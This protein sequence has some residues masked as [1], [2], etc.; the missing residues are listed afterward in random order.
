[1]GTAGECT[2]TRHLLGV[3]LLGAIDPAGRAAVDRHLA[4]CAE[5]RKEL[6]G[7]AGLPAMLSRVPAAEVYQP[8]EPALTAGQPADPGLPGLPRLL[9]GTATARRTRRWRGLAVAAAAVVLAATLGAGMQHMLSPQARA[10]PEVGSWLA[11]SARNQQTLASA[12][13]A[14]SARGWG[15]ALDVRVRQ[16]PAGTTCQ[17]WVI[18][19]SGQQAEAGNWTITRGTQRAGYPASTSFAA[20]TLRSFA[21]TTGHRT[22][23]SI[24]VTR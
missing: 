10:G 12:T 16:V 11:V 20:S 9:R 19:R 15:T 4:Q 2:Q 6:A 5:C 22:L 18:N 1:M 23:V 14:Y 8:G 13:V 7:L 21:I 24:P 17:L 3:Y